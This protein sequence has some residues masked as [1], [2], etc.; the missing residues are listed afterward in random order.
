VLFRVVG[1]TDLPCG[2]KDSFERNLL[3]EA[4]EIEPKAMHT[5]LDAKTQNVAD[6]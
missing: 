5:L 2:K 6:G 3:P 1:Y 4:V